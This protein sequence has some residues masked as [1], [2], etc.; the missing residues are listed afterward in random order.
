MAGADVV[1]ARVDDA[2]V[3]EAHRLARE[4]PADAPL[5]VGA[6][7]R[8]ET[9]A[10]RIGQPVDQRDVAEDVAPPDVGAV[11]LEG[12]Q[13]VGREGHDDAPGPR[14]AH[15]LGHGAPVVVDVLDDLVGEDEV[16]VVV[17]VG[18]G[19]ADGQHD[20]GQAA[21]GWPPPTRS[22]STSMPWTSSRVLAEA[23]HVG[24]DA[25]AHVEDARVL[26][27]HEAA[28]HLQ[29][30]VLA[31]APRVAGT[32]ALDGGL[33]GLLG[34]GWGRRGHPRYGTAPRRPPAGRRVQRARG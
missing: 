16:E 20:V 18:Q 28:H 29:P 7:V 11:R 14:H 9:V 4:E 22:G 13:A 23:T 1:E 25:A 6:H 21:V 27:V 32:P 8:R 5:R 34:L 3:D 10:Q 19:L 2:V 12:V 17:R 33:R 15:H 30:A 24:A 31:V 26:E